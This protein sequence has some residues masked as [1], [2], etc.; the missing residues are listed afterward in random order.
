MADKTI[1]ELP[2]AREM[3]YESLFVMEQQGEAMSLKGQVIANFAKESVNA[4]I[5]RAQQAANAA[6][7]SATSAAGSAQIAQQYSGK[8]PKPQN[9]TWWIWNA[10]SGKYEDSGIKSILSIVKSYPSIDE[11]WADFDNMDNGDLVIIATDVE[12]EDNS[13]LFIH[14]SSGWVYLSDLSGLQG[15]GIANI[16]WTGGNHAP[17]TVDTYTVTLTDGSSY[18]I[19][20]L[21]GPVGPVGPTGPQGETGPTGPQ[22][23]QGPQ[24]P[25]GPSGGAMVETT[26]AYCFSVNE[27]GRLILHYTGDEVPDFYI[28]ET[29][30]HLYLNIT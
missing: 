26:G 5:E 22:G 18:E 19:Q 4:E 10:S 27:N 28:N 25:P 7:N 13:K 24:G 16:A 3:D 6:A 30:G 20:V 1:G 15:V 23:I 12:I 9:G 29:D 14:A 8:P 2:V 11:M 17:G 21:N